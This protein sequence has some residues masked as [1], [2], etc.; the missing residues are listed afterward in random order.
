MTTMGGFGTGYP[1]LFRCT[2]CKVMFRSRLRHGYSKR[3]GTN[4]VRTG[5]IKPL[6]ASQ[7]GRCHSR[8]LL[9]RVEYECLDCGHVGWTRNA[10]VEGRPAKAAAEESKGDE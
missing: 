9:H 3:D 4:V 5:R 2:R 8:A 10:D 1:N 7:K 6:L